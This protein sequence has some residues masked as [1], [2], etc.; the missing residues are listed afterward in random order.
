MSDNTPPFSPRR[1]FLS[2]VATAAAVIAGSTIPASLSAM[3][4]RHAAA[5]FDDSWTARVKAARHRAVFDCPAVSDGLALQHAW[6]FIEG[7]KEQLDTADGEC[8]PVVVMRHEATVMAFNDALWEKYSIGEYRKVTD[9]R[10]KKDAVRNPFTHIDKDEK[11]ALVTAQASFESLRAMGAVFLVCNKAAMRTAGV[12]A[13]KLG[14][15]V[16]TVRNDIRNGLVPGAVLQP[17]GIYAVLRAQDV[18]CT[19]IKST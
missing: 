1:E 10:T 19:F 16:E 3:S 4:A 8:I 12:F 6:F 9:P 15:D 17:S 13:Q 14:I 5:P 2:H 7:F 18:G 11:N